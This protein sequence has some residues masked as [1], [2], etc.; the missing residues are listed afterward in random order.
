[1]SQKSA[2]SWEPKARK[3]SLGIQQLDSRGIGGP[4]YMADDALRCFAELPGEPVA[5]VR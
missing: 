4:R 1:M 5:V 3:S 2:S